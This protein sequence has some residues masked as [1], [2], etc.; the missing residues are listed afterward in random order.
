MRLQT[1]PFGEH[2]LIVCNLSKPEATFDQ[3]RKTHEK[4]KP[5]DAALIATALVEAGRCATAVYDGQ[6]YACGPEKHD[7]LVKAVLREVSQI[8]TSEE[9]TEDGKKRTKAATK[10]H[11]ETPI[12]LTIGLKASQDAGESYLNDRNDLK[13]L[14]SDILEEGIE[15]HYAP[16]DIGV[17]WAVERTNWQTLSGGDVVRPVIVSAEFVDASTAIELGPGGKKKK[18][19][20]KKK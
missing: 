19:A 18:R 12:E 15:Y 8:N 17:H 9:K 1:T 6:E 3:I 16:T 10:V 2:P 5:T 7:D 14:L 13:T 4:L 20:R 11:E